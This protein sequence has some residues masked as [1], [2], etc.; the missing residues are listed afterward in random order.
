MVNAVSIARYSAGNEKQYRK[1]KRINKAC[2][3][4]KRIKHTEGR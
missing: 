3:K 4:G 2:R 1:G